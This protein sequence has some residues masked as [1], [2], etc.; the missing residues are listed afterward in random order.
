MG[1]LPDFGYG[2]DNYI[3]SHHEAQN[4]WK[5]LTGLIG[6]NEKFEWLMRYIQL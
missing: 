1:T 4:K 5:L 3:L 6:D 2:E